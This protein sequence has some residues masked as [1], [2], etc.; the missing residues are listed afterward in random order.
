MNVPSLAARIRKSGY[1]QIVM[2]R[3]NLV[4]TEIYNYHKLKLY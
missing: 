2:T 3:T 4:D 1:D